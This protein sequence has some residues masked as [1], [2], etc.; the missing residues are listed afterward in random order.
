MRQIV[1]ILL[2]MIYSVCST[3]AT[4]Y[5]HQCGKSTSIS[6]LEEVL[7]SHDNCPMC[8][9]H[10]M[11]HHE[12][13]QQDFPCEDQDNCKDVQIELKSDIE[14]AQTKTFY[15]SLFNFIPTIVVIPWLIDYYDATIDYAIPTLIPYR[16]SLL[17]DIDPI[18]LLNCT[19]II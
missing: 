1:A 7:V 16:S 4:I 11:S 19:F 2:L 3:G 14:Q 10:Q 9:D 6:V 5:M 12:N 8:I 17:T 15:G 13:D 18:F